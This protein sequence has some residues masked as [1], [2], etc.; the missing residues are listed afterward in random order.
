MKTWQVNTSHVRTG[1]Y[2]VCCWLLFA[3][4]E[5]A[6]AGDYVIVP[7]KTKMH[8]P[9]MPALAVIEVSTE[10]ADTWQ[11]TGVL[12]LK[13]EVAHRDCVAHFRRQGWELDKAIPMGGDGEQGELMTFR[14]KDRTLLLMLWQT[15]PGET[16]FSLGEQDKR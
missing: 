9:Q 13:R 2:L 11:R 8:L 1:A 15:R 5:I 12:P 7:Y 10:K 16:G 14:Q 4:V 6:G 3:G